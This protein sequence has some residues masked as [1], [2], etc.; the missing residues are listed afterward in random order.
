[1]ICFRR[2]SGEPD[3]AGPPGAAPQTAGTRAGDQRHTDQQAAAH[4]TDLRER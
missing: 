3:D 1:M 4:N 2:G